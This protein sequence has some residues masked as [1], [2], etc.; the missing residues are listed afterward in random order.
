MDET[1][2]SREE[3]LLMR[4]KLHWRCGMRRMRQNNSSA[5]LSTLY[6]ALFS[7]MRWYILKNFHYEPGDNTDE[8]LENER[9]VSSILRKSGILDSSFDL[10]FF[11]TIVDKSLMG[12]EVNF[13]PNEVLLQL[14]HFLTRLGM[15][16]F[17]DSELPPED[18]AIL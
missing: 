18:L 11:E 15:L 1:K 13:D 10:K 5:G 6:D 16:P 12:E 7:A 14:D 4:A 2:M 9:V 3:G 17:D 8:M